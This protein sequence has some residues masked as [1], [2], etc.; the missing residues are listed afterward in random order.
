VIC[1]IAAELWLVEDPSRTMDQAWDK[2][3]WFV[4]FGFG[5]WYI[6]Q[7]LKRLD[8]ADHEIEWLNEMLLG[9]KNYAEDM[10]KGSIGNFVELRDRLDRLEGR[11]N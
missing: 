4:I 3:S 6:Y 2:V 9:V 10:R 1:A 8:K 11:R 5:C 7:L